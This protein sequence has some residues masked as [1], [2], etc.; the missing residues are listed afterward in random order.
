MDAQRIQ[1]A[2]QW[3]DRLDRV[4]PFYG[5][6][7]ELRV[8]VDQAPCLALRDWL[9]DHIAKMPQQRTELTAPESDFSV[10]VRDESNCQGCNAN[11][12]KG[13]FCIRT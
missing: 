7:H 4:D 12:C 5:D 10:L 2:G 13:I 9:T 11:C 8:L 6:V 3:H 1:Q